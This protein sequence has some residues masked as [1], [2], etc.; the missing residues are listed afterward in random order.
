MIFVALKFELLLVL[1]EELHLI[2]SF[3]L[4]VL[5][6]EMFHLSTVCLFQVSMA[7]PPLTSYQLQEDSCTE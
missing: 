2:S 7:N 6:S 5:Y 4:Y 1:F 3:V